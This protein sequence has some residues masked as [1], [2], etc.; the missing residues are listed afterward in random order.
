MPS[1]F[2][3]IRT[4]TRV[5]LSKF[6]EAGYSQNFLY[7]QFLQITKTGTSANDFIPQ[8]LASEIGSLG[9]FYRKQDFQADYREFA[10]LKKN[11]ARISKLSGDRKVPQTYMVESVFTKE[12]KYRYRGAVT[13]IDK[14]TGTLETS[15]AQWY[16]DKWSNIDE[17]INE[18]MDDYRDRYGQS[19]KEIVAVTIEQVLHNKELG[20]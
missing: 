20:Y 19:D 9:K 3:V 8:A 1:T 10:G 4:A 15:N 2:G 13:T 14:I 6:V 5:A 17:Q 18:F 11:Q 12:R 7:N 16:T